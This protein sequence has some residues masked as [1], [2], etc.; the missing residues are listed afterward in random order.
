MQSNTKVARKYIFVTGGVVSSLGKG[1]TASSLGRLL[2]ERGYRVTIQKFDPYINVDPGTMSPYQHGEVFVTDDGAETDLDLGH[3]ER[4]INENLTQYNN[5]TTGRI[6]STVI[7]K[8]RRGEF[9]GGTV[10]IVPHVTDEIK[11]NIK[12]AGDASNSDIVITEIGGTIGDIESDPFIE[13]IR[14]FKKEAGRDNILYIHVTLL[15]YLKAAGELKTKP[16]Q[17]SVKMLQSLGISPDIIVLR[18]EH[19]VDQNIKKKISLFC[20]IE[21]E[22]VIEANDAEILYEIPLTM[23]RLGLADVACK[24]LGLTAEKP[25]LAE[26]KKMIEKFKNPKKIMKVAVVGKYVELKDAYMSINESIEHAGFNKDT[27]VEIEYLQAENIDVRSLKNY[28][29]IL[30][31]GGFGDRGIEGKL[32]AI[33][34]ARENKI[35]FLG[36]CLGMQTATIEFA[37][38][39]LGYEGATSTE[40][41]KE[42]PYPIISLMAEQEG[43]EDMGG[44]MRLGAYPCL[45]EE[46]SKISQL[47]NEKEI[48]ERHRHRF[49][50]N[51]K[52]KEVFE[53]NGMKI[54][55]TSPDGKYVEAV[56][57]ENHPYFIAVQYH[58]EFKSRPTNPH[59]LFSGWIEAILEKR[60]K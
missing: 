21:E 39:V 58:P 15:P 47:Y 48:S 18:S 17:H 6:M 42:T 2:K 60:E 38:N 25:S 45:L 54:V 49:E 19:M 27:K 5:L 11:E 3:Y 33:R 40:F 1:I 57:L 31:P 56:E 46:G 22:A 13:A 44:T 14:Q 37:R 36:I 41:D 29:G 26:W 35:P 51:N 30:V 16:T 34:Y 43:V 10:Q 55:G 32:E 12:R 52:Y 50:F 7:S 59:P 9:L 24:Y 28:E 8:E 23:E 20:D 53:K 4:F